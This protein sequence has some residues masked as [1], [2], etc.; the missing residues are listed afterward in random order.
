MSIEPSN[1]CYFDSLEIQ[2]QHTGS[3]VK[4]CG[5]PENYTHQ[6]SLL[7]IV[8]GSSDVLL[9]FHSDESQTDRGFVLDYLQLSDAPTHCNW[10]NFTELSGI[11]LIPTPGMCSQ[12]IYV[13]KLKSLKI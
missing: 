5:M 12:L 10:Y 3:S 11:T 6:G 2:D 4:I 8:T 9:N 13:N 1:G 7:C